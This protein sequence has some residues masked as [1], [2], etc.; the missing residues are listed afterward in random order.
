MGLLDVE[1]MFQY[2]YIFIDALLLVIWLLFIIRYKKW[3]ALKVSIMFSVL[4][5]FIDA[6]WWWN[7]PWGTGGFIREYWLGT[8]E[9]YVQHPLDPS[10]LLNLL[11]FGSDFMMTISYSLYAF[12]WLWIIF[13]NIEKKDVEEIVLFT[14]LFFGFWMILPWISILLP[15]NDLPVRTVRH[16]DTQ[17]IIWIVNVFVGY[18]LLS[19]MYGT[20]LFKSK[21][22]KTILYVFVI[23]CTES[24]FM[25]FPLFVSGI[26][27]IN[28]WFLIY[29]IFFLFNQGAPYLYILYDKIF[30]LLLKKI[31]TSKIENSG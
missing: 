31:K 10:M 15:I 21:D 12:T 14:T 4:V 11:K 1:R 8:P 16:M 25:E 9:T 6:I 18:L 17:L 23:G 29:E 2:D 28:I 7:S 22:P 30:P 5:Y 3:K 26:R 13:E 24:F 20:N 19:I 27:P